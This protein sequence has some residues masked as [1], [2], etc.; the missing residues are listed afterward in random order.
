MTLASAPLVPLTPDRWVY[1]LK[2][3][4]QPDLAPDGQ[5]LVYVVSEPSRETGKASSQVW[6]SDIDGG[7]QRQL[8]WRN[9][10][11]SSPV[12]SPDGTSIAYVS[13]RNEGKG[14]G[15][16][17]LSLAGGEPREVTAHA[18]GP[19]HLAWSPDGKTI[20]YILTVDPENPDEDDRDPDKPAPIR[21]VTRPDYKQDG[22]GFVNDVRQQLF[23]VDIEAGTRRQLTT[24]AND[25]TGPRWSPGGGMLGIQRSTFHGLYYQLVLIDLATGTETVIGENRQT[26]R[27][28]QWTEDGESLLL[29]KAPHYAIGAS[30]VVRDLASGAERPVAGHFDWTP[31]TILGWTTGTTALLGGLKAGLGGL[32]TLDTVEGASEAPVQI[33]SFPASPQSFVNNHPSVILTWNASDRTGELAVH[34]LDTGETIFIT[35]LNDAFFAETPSTTVERH[36]VENEG[37][38]IEYWLTKP[39]GFD[40]TQR[41]PVVLDIHGGPH[42]AHGDGFNWAAQLLAAEGYLV[43]SPNPRGSS[44][45]GDAFAEAVIGDWGGGDWH[46][47]LAAL[48]AVLELPY[49]DPER[50]GVYGYSYG[51]Y[52]SS[53]AI[54]QTTRF[55]AAVIGAPITDLIA[56]YGT[57]DIGHH[58]GEFQWGGNVR[59]RWEHLQERSP[60]THAHKATTPALLLHPEED[61]RCPISGSEQLFISLLHAGVETEL[62]RYPGQSHLMPWS[63]PAEYR[64]DFATRLLAWFDRFLKA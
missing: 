18:G 62:V 29:I 50:T 10:P 20:A 40:A 43:I 1:D 37:Y 7:N 13:T 64:V 19:S 34:N 44:S 31:F 22:R 2:N 63:G 48:D 58:G 4:S 53:W 52:M 11:H 15:I 60:I 59:E 25:H 9:E 35:H 56:N 27:A 12:W 16:F 5:R 23:V 6:L 26:I 38:T 24:A 54:G 17:V 36:Q 46:D 47:D 33:A 45:Y 39:A 57:A 30:I 55:K 61:Q 14:S 51:G 28:W 32:W 41:Y 42:G 8:T 49:A 3:A 21:V